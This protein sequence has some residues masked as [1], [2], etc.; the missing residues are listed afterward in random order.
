MPPIS[1]DSSVQRKNNR[2]KFCVEAKF[3][4]DAHRPWFC[5]EAK[6]QDQAISDHLGYFRD[7]LNIPYAF[8]VIRTPGIDSVRRGV[9]LISADRF[10][11]ALL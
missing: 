7:R 6:Y 9:R 8:Q 4:D 5:V 2:E 10:L 3:H 11:A 1:A